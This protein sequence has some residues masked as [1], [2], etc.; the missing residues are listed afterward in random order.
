MTSTT[1]L[2]LHNILHCHHEED[3]AT[4]TGNKHIKF[5]EVWVCSL[6]NICADTQTDTQTHRSQYFAK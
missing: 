1:K 3:R 6:K 2:E 4:D 5:G